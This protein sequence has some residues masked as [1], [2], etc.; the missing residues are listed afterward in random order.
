MPQDMGEVRA[1]LIQ[2][3]H[4]LDAWMTAITNIRVELETAEAG[5]VSTHLEAMIAYENIAEVHESLGSISI[6][7]PAVLQ[8]MDLAG[9]SQATVRREFMRL[10]EEL[11]TGT[12]ARIL[13]ARTML[14]SYVTEIER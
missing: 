4:D 5:L 12:Y 1:K 13:R 7:L 10:F 6:T 11:K 8:A 2:A 9:K 14:D 3:G